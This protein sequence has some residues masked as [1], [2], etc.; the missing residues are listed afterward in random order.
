[1]YVYYTYTAHMYLVV[2]GNNLV[3]FGLLNERTTQSIRLQATAIEER[4]MQG[5]HTQGP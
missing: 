2:E 3:A 5:N 4:H 1:M